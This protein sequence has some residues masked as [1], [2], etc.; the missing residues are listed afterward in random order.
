MA[1]LNMNSTVQAKIAKLLAL[2]GNN[3]SQEEAQAAML[4]ARALM[5]EY[6]LRPEDCEVKDRAVI[7]QLVGVRCTARTSAWAVSL[8][9]IIASHYCCVAYRQHEKGSQTQQIGFYGLKEDFEICAAIFRYA[10]RTCAL[11][12]EAERAYGSQAAEAYGW[13]FCAGLQAAFAAQEQTHEEWGLVM[14]TPKEVQDAVAGKK[15]SSYGRDKGETTAAALAR[16]RGYEDGKHFDPSAK[17]PRK[18]DERE[19]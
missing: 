15:R 11:E 14:V 8:S 9:G 7:S 13:G 6:K 10:Y 5:A 2:A 17:L 19:R 4:K 3:P 12:C 18:K 1:E 16:R